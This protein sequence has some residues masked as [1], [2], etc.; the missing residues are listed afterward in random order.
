M[1]KRWGC[2]GCGKTATITEEEFDEKWHCE[3]CEKYWLY[4]DELQV[5]EIDHAGKLITE[6]SKL[7]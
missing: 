7:G 2:W 1:K 4:D 6:N 5:Y 3:C